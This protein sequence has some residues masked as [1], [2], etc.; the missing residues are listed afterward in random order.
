M[1][2]SFVCPPTA[3]SASNTN[4]R[5]GFTYKY[6]NNKASR[7][8]KPRQKDLA[9][10]TLSHSVAPGTYSTTNLTSHHLVGHEGLSALKPLADMARQ[11]TEENG[12]YS[13]ESVSTRA[14]RTKVSAS[15]RERCRINQ[16][17]Y[18]KRQRQH[19]EEL[20]NSI[21]ELQEKIQEL[22]TQ[23]QDMMRSAPQSESMWVKATEY[24]RLFRHGY[25]TPMTTPESSPSSLPP[26]RAHVQL[27]YLQ[28]SMTP[29]V[30]EGN[31]IGADAILE[32]WKFLSLQ[33]DD[34]HLQLKR[35]EQIGQNSL[36]ALTATSITI[37]KN[38]L[39]HVYPHLTGKKSHLAAKLLDQRLAMR[40]S[41]RF[42]W[43][44]SLGRMTRVESTVDM[45]S[46]MLELLGSLDDV[47]LVF[48]KALLTPDG[49]ITSRRS[50]YCASRD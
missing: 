11:H 48:D 42:D 6:D 47:V 10:R 16:A 29:D 46:P 43:D 36:L 41:V 20:D 15:R 32:K 13:T 9:D 14:R 8:T 3:H 27:D 39:C 22:Q 50:S 28:S 30:T 17:R 24:F 7:Y 44:A 37:T 5:L 38:T 2:S 31:L 12:V 49:R 45:L 1:A 18:R 26:K 33:H 40:G 34:V 4:F 35:L 25:M 23:H 19:E 21:R